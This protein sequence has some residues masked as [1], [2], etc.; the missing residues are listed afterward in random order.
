MVIDPQ[1][2]IHG[3][4]DFN[5][6]LPPI[7]LIMMVCMGIGCEHQAWMI[8]STDSPFYCSLKCQNSRLL[9]EVIL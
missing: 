3:I 9:P 1:Q 2:V 5:P 7:D 6:F 8:P 4:P